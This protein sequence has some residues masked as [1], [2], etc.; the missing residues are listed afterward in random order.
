MPSRYVEYRDTADGDITLT[1]GEVS[2]H[3][4]PSTG[5]L[6]R[7]TDVEHGHNI[8]LR[9]QVAHS[10]THTLARSLARSNTQALY[11]TH[12]YLH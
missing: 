9:Q 4:S 8:T 11:S 7:V 2:L 3:I 5:L 1:N 10:H 12:R 6:S